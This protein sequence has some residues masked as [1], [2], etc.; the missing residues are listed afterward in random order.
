[1]NYIRITD[2]LWEDMLDDIRSLNRRIVKLES[3][4]QSFARNNDGQ[5]TVSVSLSK[6]NKLI[7]AV[8]LMLLAN[9]KL[10]VR[11]ID[12]VREALADMDE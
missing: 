7:N 8:K 12:R 4:R 11:T 10:P 2:V 3:P 6:Y 1:M 9:E 5:C